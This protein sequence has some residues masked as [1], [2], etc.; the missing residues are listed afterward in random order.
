MRGVLRALDPHSYYVSRAE[1]EKRAALEHGELFTVGISLEEV[2]GVPT[3]LSVFRRSPAEKAGLL[4]GDRLV[5]LND[6]S[7]AGLD[8]QTIELRLAGEK[9]SKVQ[10]DRSEEHTSELQSRSDI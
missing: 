3:V 5:T 6:T 9:G 2:D 7:V 8:V 1:A 4:A 10:L